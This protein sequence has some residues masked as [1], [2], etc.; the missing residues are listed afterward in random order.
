MGRR[1]LVLWLMVA[2]I[3]IGVIAI[4]TSVQT[5]ECK[6]D[7]TAPTETEFVCT[8]HEYT[9][10]AEPAT[11][12]AAELISYECTICGDKYSEKGTDALGHTNE[13]V[14]VDEPSTGWVGYTHYECSVCH[15]LTD[16]EIPMLNADEWPKGYI[17]DT[18]KITIYKEWYDNA[19][20]YAAHL[21]F[22]DYARLST[23]SAYG[24]YN[25]GRERVSAA[26]ERIGA[27]F[28]VN[29]DWAI[30][31]NM[32]NSYAIARN[33]VV[34]YNRSLYAQGVYDNKTGMLLN[35]DELG[36]TGKQLND[37]IEEGLFT[38][39][40]QFAE[41]FLV[42]GEITASQSS[43]SRAQRT[44]IGTNGNPGDIWVCVSDGRNNDGESTGLTGYQCAKFLQ[45][46]GCTFGLPLDGGGSST[47]CFQG[48][49]LNA[50]GKNER[51]V[52][53]FLYFK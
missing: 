3:I 43:Q 21:E 25:S 24:K 38:D 52:A 50:N 32:A 8:E 16:E 40:F 46:K 6:P 2:A 15:E 19:W 9:F 23:D 4:T 10:T 7:E 45:D 20:V 18:A 41:K 35:P 27:V 48:E 49:V 34:C 13:I 12:T 11:C 42:N 22:T 28:I 53:D 26:S 14:S 51:A 44:F 47:M 33:G 31:G 1:N 5:T 29:G 17:D 39:T 30:P 36:V 37:V